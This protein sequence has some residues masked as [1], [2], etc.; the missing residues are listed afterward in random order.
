MSR[1]A[2][3]ESIQ[4]L[5]ENMNKTILSSF[6]PLRNTLYTL[7]K[8]AKNVELNNNDIQ[9]FYTY[10]KLL[11][12]QA[13]LLYGN[14][15]LSVFLRASFRS[16][17]AVEKR[18]NLKYVIFTTTELYKAI[19]GPKGIWT[20][21]RDS[22]SS[23]A[24]QPYV[25][26]IECE[27]N[28]FRQ[29]FYTMNDKAY[30]DLAVHYDKNPNKVYDFLCQISEDVETKRA[31]AFLAITEAYNRLFNYLSLAI[32]K[33]DNSNKDITIKNEDIFR[34]R[35]DEIYSLL[36]NEIFSIGHKLDEVQHSYSLPKVVESAIGISGISEQ[37][38]DILEVAHLGT[39][40]DLLYLDIATATRAY[41]SSES[42]IEKTIHLARLNLITYEGVK[43]IYDNEPDSFWQKY[44]VDVISN[45]D[46][47]TQDE[48]KDVE[49]LLSF[50]SEEGFLFDEEFRHNYAH[51][52]NGNTNRLPLFFDK[53]QQL[54]AFKELNRT[55]V[56]LRIPPKIMH[57]N[58]MAFK[59][60]GLEF[61][62]TLKAQNRQRMQKF[63]D[64]IDKIPISEEQKLDLRKTLESIETLPYKKRN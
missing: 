57:L 2:S 48:I 43:K 18:F 15:V 35:S 17:S 60:A 61:N 12:L 24:V 42:S 51:I 33:D 28:R 41:L 13:Y 14:I 25:V 53:I 30:R 29:I 21:L 45:K 3:Q 38:S 44:I 6:Y 11:E 16:T 8:L 54:D 56:L 50:A 10:K 46:Q 62:N 1:T 22:F 36:E 4:Q 59:T 31:S 27:L 39:H 55:L 58:T 64:F 19:N 32:L 7:N 47:M 52:R 9:K 63:Y 49:F 40:I 34:D 5:S 26:E 37:M 20:K 23:D